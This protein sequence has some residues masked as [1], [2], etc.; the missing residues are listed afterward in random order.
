MAQVST[1]HSLRKRE[2]VPGGPR[3]G[4]VADRTR[5]VSAY[6]QD[7]RQIEQGVPKDDAA[8]LF[9]RIAAVRAVPAGRLRA[10]LIPDS[11]WKRSNE[12]LRHT[13]SQT[14]ARLRRVLSLATRVLE[15]EGEAIAWLTGAHE[16]LGGATP[17]SMLRTEAGGRAVE[18]LLAA[19]EYG[20][21]A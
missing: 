8:R 16:M 2:M 11:S 10:E 7:V 6:L 3:R 21:P 1:S 9:Q 15:D 5:A 19:I 12:R 13:A 18:D 4:R 17:F 20:F 14:T